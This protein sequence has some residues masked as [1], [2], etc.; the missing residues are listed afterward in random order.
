MVLG[1][2]AGEQETTAPPF[3]LQA[4]LCAVCS[5]PVATGSGCLQ[6]FVTYS[7]DHDQSFADPE[8]ILGKNRGITTYKI[9]IPCPD[10][11]AHRHIITRSRAAFSI[12]RKAI[13]GTGI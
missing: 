12:G 4:Y 5:K 10:F 6:V 8:N 2:D 11:V 7:R 3:I 13:R 1:T 9:D